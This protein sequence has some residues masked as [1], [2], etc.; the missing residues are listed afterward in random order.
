MMAYIHATVCLVN[1]TLVMG[2]PFA[3]HHM[4]FYD[5]ARQRPAMTDTC[6][7]I[8]HLSR[9]YFKIGKVG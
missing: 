2:N 4:Q 8:A 7:A 6:N 1:K 3:A 5:Y 9:V